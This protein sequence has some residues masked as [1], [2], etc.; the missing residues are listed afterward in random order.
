[1]PSPAVTSPNRAI[2]SNDEGLLAIIIDG[3]PWKHSS[4]SQDK[5]PG[6]PGSHQ[7]LGNA[8]SRKETQG[9]LEVCGQADGGIDVYSSPQDLALR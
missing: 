2:K 7:R 8:N 5:V 9:E 1:M 6:T 3:A 4:S